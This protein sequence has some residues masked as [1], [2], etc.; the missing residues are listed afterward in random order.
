MEGHGLQTPAMMISHW[1]HSLQYQRVGTSQLSPFS[2][3]S[4][5]GQSSLMHA[6]LLGLVQKKG[7][8]HQ[9]SR[10]G[11]AGM[12]NE[13][14]CHWTEL[15]LLAMASLLPMSMVKQ[16][17][18]QPLSVTAGEK[19]YQAQTLAFSQVRSR[20]LRFENY[21]WEIAQKH[22]FSARTAPGNVSDGCSEAE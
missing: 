19:P 12:L 6:L 8:K 7:C 20:I 18:L 17:S 16:P 14:T 21:V 4:C 9:V 15:L 13:L 3:P 10:T 11:S 22:H 5:P 1:W 2:Q